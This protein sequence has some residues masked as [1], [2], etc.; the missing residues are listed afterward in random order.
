MRAEPDAGRRRQAE[1][2]GDLG[3]YQAGAPG[4]VV[5]AI[6][7]RHLSVRRGGVVPPDVVPSGVS[8]MGGPAVEFDDEP[9]RLVEHVA[10]PDRGAAQHPGLPAAPRQPVRMYPAIR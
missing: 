7:Q 6:T 2:R 5:P 10:V 4:D 9:E 1:G 3:G 8:W